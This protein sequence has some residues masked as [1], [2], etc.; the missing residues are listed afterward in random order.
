MLTSVLPPNS[1]RRSLA[2]GAG[3]ALVLLAFTQLYLKTPV[4]ILF[5]ALTVGMVGSLTAAGIVLIYRTQRFVNF[6]QAAI[7][8]AG[9][10]VCFNLMQFRGFP[11]IVAFVVGLVIATLVGLIVEFGIIK[12]FFN[13]P[14]LVLTV[15]SIALAEGLPGGAQATLRQL[16]PFVFPDQKTSSLLDQL[17]A[18]TPKLPYEGFTFHVGSL[19]LPF[20]FRHIF[21]IDAAILALLVLAAF[22]RFTRAGVAVR[23]V[24]EN[25]DRARLLGISVGSM[26]TLVWMLAAFL[27]GVGVI[28]AST[29]TTVAAATGAGPGLLL[30]ALAAAV[31]AKM[32]SIPVAVAASVGIAV[33]EQSVNFTKP[34]HNSLVPV[35]L[36]LVIVVGLVLQRRRGGRSEGDAESTWQATAEQRAVPREMLAVPGVR[37]GRLAII[38]LGVLG[39]VAFPFFASTGLTNTGSVIAITGI[40]GVSLVVLT[41]WAGQA[42][43]GQFGFV[44]IGAV[45]GGS[46]IG[47]AHVPFLLAFLIVPVIV[48]AIAVVVGLPALRIKGLFLAVTTF[49][50]AVAV[51]TA[52]F[53]QKY[54]SWLLPD[55]VPRPRLFL[56]DL[57]SE[58]SMYFLCLV[59]LAVTVVLV[60]NLRRS[61]FGRILIAARENE[62]NL[63]SFGVNL[64]RTKLMAFAVSGALCGFAGVLLAIQQQAVTGASFGSTASIDVF[65]YSVL[66]GVGSIPGVL[67]GII[68]RGVTQDIVHSD[69]LR[70]IIGP[71]GLL[72][73]LYIAPGGLISI[74]NQMR[75][76]ALRIIAQRRQMI[77]PSLFADMDPD[78]LAARLIPL[79]EPDPNAGLG[80]LP[81]GQRFQRPSELYPW[82]RADA[83]AVQRA[84]AGALTP[85]IG[86][87][88]DGA[89][90][91][92]G[93]RPG[94]E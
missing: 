28:L 35:G 1:N 61:R 92:S 62:P 73:I 22:F 11:F 80:T 94:G 85:G 9:A 89:L 69:F 72:L 40:V 65:L 76:A 46:L 52:L 87:G 39:V 32:R 67:L 6:S 16:I 14:R 54:F 25:A 49:A 74:V 24:A 71:G 91:T 34:E 81:S 79:A 68:F 19:S 5:L 86:N 33:V 82:R 88:D 57:Q 8:G 90:T 48:G 56:I 59:C 4:G 17:G 41:G 43:L 93:A 12:R 55:A 18:F 44:A 78:A 15:I 58:R 27:S 3:V 10:V 66:G 30:P 42:S 47:R 77:V 20:G 38:A 26:S 75:D 37:F 53:E 45:V 31:L 84:P 23:G 50:F 36:L 64:V 21:A 63:Q 7:G 13:Q 60:S 29:L 2:L 83:P 70:P 51:S